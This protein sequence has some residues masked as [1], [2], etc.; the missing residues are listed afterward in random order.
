MSLDPRAR[1]RRLLLILGPA[2]IVGGAAVLF[3]V[4]RMPLPLRILVGLTDIVAG[5]ALL[6]VARQ[7]FRPPPK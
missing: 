7:K 1:Q 3:L 4:T 2:L 5:C 6:L